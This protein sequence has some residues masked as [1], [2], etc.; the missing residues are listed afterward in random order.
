VHSNK[1]ENNKWP[2]RTAKHH[3]KGFSPKNLT[4]AN[5]TYTLS[6]ANRHKQLT[7]L[8]DMLVEDSTLK[9]QEEN[10]TSD[11]PNCDHLT[12]SQHQSRK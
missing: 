4:E 7:N 3:R 9:A 5:N 10:N 6:T 12:K 2:I 1:L 8:Q 11:I